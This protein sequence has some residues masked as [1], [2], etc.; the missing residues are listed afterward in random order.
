[1]PRQ[2]RVVIPNVPLHITQRGVDRCPTFLADADF[3]FYRRTLGDALAV[4]RCSVHAYVLMTNHV[5]LLVTPMDRGGPAKMMRMIGRR[6]VRYFNDRYGRTGTL[7]E[8]RFRSTLVESAHHFFACSRYIEQNPVRAQIAR[9]PRDYTWSS[10]HRNAYGREDV[11]V[12][13]HPLYSQLGGE[14]ATRTAEYR[15]LVAT[16]LAPSLIVDM[17]SAHRGRPTMFRTPYR[18]AASALLGEGTLAG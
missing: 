7:W 17:R 14:L 18:Q 2:R 6:Y 1:M 5:H 4:A 12:S 8:G 3:A 13:E 11:V 16:P 15:A 9:E 10:V